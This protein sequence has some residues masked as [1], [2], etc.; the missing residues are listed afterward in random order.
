VRAFDGTEWSNWDLFTVT[1]TNT[2]PVATIADHSLNEERFAQ[3][4]SWLSYSDADGNPATKYQFYDA[5]TDA[6]SG[7]FWT[8]T[9]NHVA[10][11]TTLEVDAADLGNVWVKGGSTGG[12]ESMWV[13]AFDGNEWGNWD[14]FT[15]TTIQNTTPVA[16]INDHTLAANTWGQVKNWLT[17]SDAN[18]DAA[19]KYQFWD[20]GTGATSGYFWTPTD[21]HHAANTTLEVLAAD[22]DS[23]WVRGGSTAGS[24]SMWVRAFD[25]HD[26]GNWDI[27]T[28]TT[29]A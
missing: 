24:E 7:Y 20:S 14:I 13:R 1:S 28:L 17:Y 23:V 22:L 18:G 6:D 5:G 8:P 27:F 2:E 29:T 11:N 3:V 21:T 12:T 9:N 25:G 10:A 16:T 4:S 26:W 15:L 19:T